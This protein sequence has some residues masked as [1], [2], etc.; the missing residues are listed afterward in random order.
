[1]QNNLDYIFKGK[2][3]YLT[4]RPRNSDKFPKRKLI[5]K[6]SQLEKYIKNQDLDTDLYITKYPKEQVVSTLIF[7]FDS[8][9]NI[10]LAKNDALT[11]FNYTKQQ[12]LNPV[13]IESGSKG[14]HVYIQHQPIGFVEK[15]SESRDVKRVFEIYCNYICGG[16]Y[17]NSTGGFGLNL[18]TLDTTNTG[19]GLNGNIRLIGSTHPTTGNKCRI[20]KGKFINLDTIND[21]EMVKLM[22]FA[23]LC[24]TKALET[25]DK[26]VEKLSKHQENFTINSS[27]NL[28]DD[29]DLRD[30]IPS[31]FGKEYKSFG[32]YIMCQC[33]EHHDRN[34]SMVITKEYYYCKS[35]Q[36]KGNIWTLVK[37]G[38]PLLDNTVK[39]KGART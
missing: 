15:H 36:A 32:D 5:F 8:K 30:V 17:Q 35:C 38:Y 12:N 7:D 11:L 9:N 29:Y 3:H 26:E 22:K 1:M 23:H 2:Q 4:I 37:N 19:A 27:A 18:T 39:T 24:F 16:L 34:P 25:Y 28:I 14:Y 21:A 10:N 31:Y 13:L 33:F 6:P 20:I